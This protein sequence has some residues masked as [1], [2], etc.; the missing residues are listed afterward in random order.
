MFCFKIS[1]EINVVCLFYFF[2]SAEDVSVK[3]SSVIKCRDSITS[4]SQQSSLVD[5]LIITFSQNQAI[6][7]PVTLKDQSL[8]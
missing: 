1:L 7:V 3:A 6:E 8:F 4:I 5:L 2:S